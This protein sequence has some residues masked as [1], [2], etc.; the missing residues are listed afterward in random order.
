MNT[1]FDQQHKFD[2]FKQICKTHKIKLT[3]QRMVI[4]EKLIA[5]N[6]H[7]SANMLYQRLHKTF[8]T[9]SFDT[10]YRTMLT[11]CDIG[12]AEIVEGTGNPKRFDGTL[13]KHHHFQCTR[14]K[15]I[16]DVHHETYDH[17]PVPEQLQAR[18]RVLRQS[19]RLEGICADCCNSE[20]Q[21]Q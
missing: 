16:I 3:P 19:V 8:P 6:D 1:T 5:H 7:P 18:C 21:E 9:I 10:V 2:Q 20:Q 4:Y 17:L 14:C 12:V 13:D 15:K 11:F